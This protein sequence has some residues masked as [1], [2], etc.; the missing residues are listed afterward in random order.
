MGRRDRAS[1]P[2][3]GARPTLSAPILSASRFTGGRSRGFLSFSSRS[4]EPFG[5]PTGSRRALLFGIDLLLH[6]SPRDARGDQCTRRADQACSQTF[7]EVQHAAE[8]SRKCPVAAGYAAYLRKHQDQVDEH[9]EAENKEN[10]LA[11][12]R[13]HYCA[14]LIGHAADMDERNAKPTSL[15]PQAAARPAPPSS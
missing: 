4:S 5:F 14:P 8:P 3:L 10:Q 1:G 11:Y 9:H 7:V 15:P 13:T 12:S 2:P 6:R